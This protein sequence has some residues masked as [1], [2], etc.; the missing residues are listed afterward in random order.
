MQEFQVLCSG[1]N[2]QQ[3]IKAEITQS[4]FSWIRNILSLKRQKPLKHAPDILYLKMANQELKVRWKAS[5]WQ[6]HLPFRLCIKMLFE[7]TELNKTEKTKHYFNSFTLLR[8]CC[9]GP[10]E[11]QGFLC[12]TTQQQPEDCRGTGGERNSQRTH[13]P[14]SREPECKWSFLICWQELLEQITKLPHSLLLRCIPRWQPREDLNQ[15]P[16]PSP[17]PRLTLGSQN[18]YTHNI[19]FSICVLFPVIIIFRGEHVCPG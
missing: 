8:S 13:I 10:S 7:F 15:A 11:P 12:Q 9:S 3:K 19:P 18:L 2:T 17:T 6:N 14:A 4:Y 1:S 16:C 5:Y